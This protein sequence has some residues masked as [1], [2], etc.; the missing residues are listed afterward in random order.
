MWVRIVATLTYNF[1][2]YARTC[3]YIYIYIRCKKLID[4]V[5]SIFI[6]SKTN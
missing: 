5:M 3:Q 4:Y 2:A 1:N 6:S